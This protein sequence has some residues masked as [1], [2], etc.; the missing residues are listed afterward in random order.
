MKYR[1]NVNQMREFNLPFIGDS[2]VDS[3]FAFFWDETNNFRSFYLK[4]QSFNYPIHANFVL[5][6]VVYDKAPE[7]LDD[8]FKGLKLQS[9]IR[10]VKLKH[11][12][13]GD[14]LKCISS[15]KVNFFLTSVLDGNG[16]VHYQ[17]VNFLYY[18][19]VDIVDSAIFNSKAGMQLGGSFD[20]YVKNALYL[21]CMKE[22]EVVTQLL[23]R[24]HYPNIKANELQLFINEVST[25]IEQY[26]D[27]FELH[28]P[29]VSLRQML[30]EAERAGSLPFIQESTDYML[31][32][33]FSGFY[34]DPICL[35]KNS[36]HVFDKED[37]IKEVLS[38]VEFMDG[39]RLMNNYSFELSESD[40]HIQASD[41]FVGIAGKFSEF[42]NTNT[43]DELEEKVSKLN[44]LQ[45]ETLAIYF[46]LIQKSIQR[47]P[48]FI[49][50]VAPDDELQKTGEIMNML[51]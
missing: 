3:S 33:D 17:N 48:A 51:F 46:A 16:W 26:E 40:N 12:A 15:P 47:N 24:F 27:I 29:L 35:F 30:R 9:N 14:F 4:E 37:S 38:G 7:A 28:V 34:T 1:I 13:K 43:Y 32:K 2:D 11:L 6:G 49:K 8:I 5:G 18:A 19:L 42:L 44:S 22:I 45:R 23:Y 31:M 36:I 41:I 20:R 39:E 10:D 50:T 21:V 25:L